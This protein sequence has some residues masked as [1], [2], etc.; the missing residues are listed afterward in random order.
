MN[1]NGSR[2][3]DLQTVSACDKTDG[4]ML[5]TSQSNLNVRLER[6][7]VNVYI[8]VHSSD[9]LAGELDDVLQRRRD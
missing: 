2:R 9:F 5:G 6:R 8:E 1:G 7:D 3:G 4:R